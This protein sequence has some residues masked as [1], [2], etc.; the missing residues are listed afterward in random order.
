MGLGI[1]EPMTSWGLLLGQAQSLSALLLYWLLIPGVFIVL[2]VLSFNFVGESLRDVADP[3]KVGEEH[4]KY[5]KYF[6]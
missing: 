3:Y 5:R 1:K 2:A 4:E 6:K